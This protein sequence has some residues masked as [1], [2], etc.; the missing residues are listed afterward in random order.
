MID[1]KRQPVAPGPVRVPREVFTGIEA[2]R[3]SGLTNMFDRPV[4]IQLAETMGF[5][6]TARWV[7]AH[8]DL[9]ATGIFQ[10]FEVEEKV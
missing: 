9:Y 3:E 6:E 7:E 8:G 5:T 1:R 10:G 4:V 2:V